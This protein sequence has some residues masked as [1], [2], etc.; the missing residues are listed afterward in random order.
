M[1]F[2]FKHSALLLLL[3]CLA[4][5]CST[6]MPRRGAPA[7]GTYRQKLNER[8]MGARRQYRLHIPAG[9]RPDKPAA[10][11][12]VLHG[13]F[14]TARRMEQTSGFSEVS[15]REGFLVAYPSGAYG[16]FGLLHHWNAGHCCGKAADDDLDDV[17]FLDKVIDDISQRVA[18]DESRIYMVGFSNGG[19]LT[20]RYAAERTQRLAAAAPVGAALSG[21][22]SSQEP[23]WRPP[24]PSDRLPMIIFHARD[25][26]SVPYDG[27]ISPRKGGEREYGSVAKS[28]H[29]WLEHNQCRQEA[30]E[31]HLYGG[32]VLRETWTDPQGEPAVILY[33]IKAWGHEW[34]GPHA[35][36]ALDPD[37]AFRTFNA[38]DII[39]EF[40][41]THTRP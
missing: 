15:D 20:H 34:P 23:W 41:E 38:A 28:V 6:S 32:R 1:R 25:D 22:A 26:D 3:P 17:G 14:S 12:L 35:M 33:S 29:F 21:R 8:V 19:M 18:V 11:V 37:D 13:A 5:Q 24:T 39:W 16:L 31:E 36:G 2:L 40:F 27:G 7:P 9:H 30:T 4:W 10:L